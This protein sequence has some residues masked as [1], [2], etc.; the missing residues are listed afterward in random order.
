MLRIDLA[1]LDEGSTCFTATPTSKDLD[2]DSFPLT[3]LMVT[4]TLVRA[5][6]HISVLLEVQARAHLTCDR[7]L[8]TYEQLIKGTYRLLLVTAANKPADTGQEQ[9]EI[10][11]L[12]PTQR[13]MDLSEAVRDTLLL[14]IP[15]RKVAPGA[16][17]REI[18]TVFGAPEQEDAIDQRWERLRVLY[19]PSTP[20]LS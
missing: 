7:T 12:E 5:N 13:Y 17:N 3:G 1:T 11:T 4:I 6:G 15:V 2:L 20:P 8:Q 16:E 14:S 19:G 10:V 9:E 18:P